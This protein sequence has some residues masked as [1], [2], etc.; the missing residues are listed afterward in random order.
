MQGL[1]GKFSAKV[2]DFVVLS[3]DNSYGDTALR[4]GGYV[5]EIK[6]HAWQESSVTLSHESPNNDGPIKFFSG[7]RSYKLKDFD[8]YEVLTPKI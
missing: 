2:G 6:A 8:S 4:I 1:E 3:K 7:D 5:A